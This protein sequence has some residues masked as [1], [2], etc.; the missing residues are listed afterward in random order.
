MICLILPPHL[1]LYLLFRRAHVSPESYADM[2]WVKE[3]GENDIDNWKFEI[4]I[5]FGNSLK[6]INCHFGIVYGDYI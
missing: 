3:V 6:V 2:P 5:V 1:L 4:P